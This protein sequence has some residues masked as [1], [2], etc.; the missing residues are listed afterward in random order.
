MTTTAVLKPDHAAAPISAVDSVA[1]DRDRRL[2]LYRLIHAPSQQSAEDFFDR[3]AAED[4][5]HWDPYT[6]TWLVADRE[7][8]LRVLNDPAFSSRPSRLV[9]PDLL[10][11]WSRLGDLLSRQLLFLDGPAHMRLRSL[12]HQAL[13]ARRVRGLVDEITSMAREA[14]G[15]G[16]YRAGGGGRRCP[17][18]TTR[19]R[20][21]A[22]RA[23]TC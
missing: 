16:F 15:E 5:V 19:H 21:A 23:G 11:P 22:S 8:A 20:R 7:A 9:H 10:P 13:S 14:S 18:D 2:S 3:V 1:R 4:P 17:P 12:I 6:H